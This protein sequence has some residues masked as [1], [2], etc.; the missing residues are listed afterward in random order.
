MYP[1][2]DIVKITQSNPFF[3]EHRHCFNHKHWCH[4][5]FVAGLLLRHA[6]ITRHHFSC[7]LQQL[8]LSLEKLQRIAKHMPLAPALITFLQ[9]ST[10]LVISFSPDLLSTICSF[11]R[12]RHTLY[13]GPQNRGFAMLVRLLVI[14]IVSLD[15]VGEIH[16]V[17]C[18]HWTRRVFQRCERLLYYFN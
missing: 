6:Q 5:D 11:P 1:L 10:T 3:V 17:N 14:H 15:H 7:L 16:V 4:I 8:F 18:A 2:H 12:F 13:G 9:I